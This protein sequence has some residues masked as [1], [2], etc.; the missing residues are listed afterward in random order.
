MRRSS[1]SILSLCIC[2]WRFLH[3][4]LKPENNLRQQGDPRVPK[5]SP[6][7]IFVEWERNDKTERRRAEE[8][9][10]N[11]SENRP[12]NETPWV[13]TGSYLKEGKLFMADATQS[14]IASFRDPAAI[15]NHP[16]PAGADDTVYRA[17]L[18]VVPPNGFPVEL[19]IRPADAP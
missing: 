2:R 4:G 16:L 17:N 5:G 3:W 19:I 18:S 7:D 1:R 6:V 13:F 14:L 9:I 15:L 11:G 8:L 12:M 10:W